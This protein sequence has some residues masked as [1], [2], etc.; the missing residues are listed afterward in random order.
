MNAHLVA[1]YSTPTPAL[2]TAQGAHW[3]QDARFGMFVHYGAYS[4]VGRGEWLMA[5]EG[6]TIEEYEKLAD[7]METDPQQV[8]GWV[9][10]AK[11][12]GMRYAVLTAK[13]HDGFS[14]WDSSVN[15]YNSVLRGPR[16][17][18][19]KI[20]VNA[21]RLEGLYTGLYYSL[22]DWHHPDG[23][24]CATDPQAKKRFITSTAECLRELL[25]NY[26]QID[27]LWFDGPWPLGKAEHWDADYLMGLIRS[28]QPNIS[29]NDRLGKGY[30]GDFATCERDIKTA[31][32]AW[33]ACMTMNDDWGFALRNEQDWVSTK[34]IAL[35]LR[36][37]SMGGGNLLLNVGPMG[38]GALPPQAQVRLDAI[39]RWL[40]VHGEAVYARSQSPDTA[41]PF[42]SNTGSWS[43]RGGVAYY[44]LWRTWPGEQLH[45][46]GLEGQLLKAELLGS[47]RELTVTR[48]P[49]RYTIGNLPTAN[50][51]SDAGVAI[52]KMTFAD[53]P[54]QK[55]PC[56]HEEF[57]W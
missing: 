28:L 3:W 13:H 23:T 55:F 56:P 21:C 39:G 15:P 16:L 54:K 50:P 2:A 29:I 12:A 30:K 1:A 9:R 27:L 49:L 45:L 52:L 57:V 5:Q 24:S 11:A 4:H 25:C 41:L 17:D 36:K 37:C 19:V 48:H 51:D 14:L 26:G 53:T 31:R 43:R 42:I 44:W 8:R 20:F 18:I 38:N 7:A 33:E 32:G 35:M 40:L 46:G 22:A 34:D 10:Q 47:T 6:W